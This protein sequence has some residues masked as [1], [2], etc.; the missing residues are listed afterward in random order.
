MFA[1]FKY[2][3]GKPK[4]VSGV[5]VPSSYENTLLPAK[6]V[7]PYTVESDKLTP[8]LSKRSNSGGWFDAVFC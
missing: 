3:I 7:D 1:I 6:L 5:P 4:T 8:L 2:L